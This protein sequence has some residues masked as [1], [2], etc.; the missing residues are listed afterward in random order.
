L[1]V[2][3]TPVK[4]DE[5]DNVVAVK[6]RGAVTADQ[7]PHQYESGRILIP[8]W[9]L[10]VNGTKAKMRFDGFEKIA[11]ISD[12]T[13]PTETASCKFVASQAGRYA[14]SVTYCSDRTAAGSTATLNFNGDRIDFTSADT[15]GWSGGNYRVRQCGTITLARPG[16]QELAIVPVTEGWKNVALKQ[17]LLT[18]EK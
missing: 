3:L 5:D 12:W 10:A 15:G 16:E 18:P 9:S 7:R 2:D 1:H 4:P 13:D 6:V 8:A 17:I 11:H 14:V